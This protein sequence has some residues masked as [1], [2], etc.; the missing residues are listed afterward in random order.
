MQTNIHAS[1]V[2][3]HILRN[4]LLV[5]YLSRNLI[6]IQSLARELLPLIQQENKKATLES[7]AV[8][9]QRLDLRSPHLLTEQLK[10]IINNVQILMR[11][12]VCLFCLEKGTIIDSRQFGKDDIFY[13]NQGAN[14]VTVIV[15]RKNK[16]LIHGQ[17]LLQ[18]DNL[19]LISLKDT[20]IK[21]STNYRVTPGFVHMFLSNISKEGINVEDI[22]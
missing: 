18:K 14:E 8:A 21:S 11:T 3:D 13:I 20:L 9:I 6:N 17:I 12:D 1:L 16:S 5:D 4:P 10:T 7:I 22:I 2:R 19:A 15:D